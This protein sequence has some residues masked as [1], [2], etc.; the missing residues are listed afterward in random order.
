MPVRRCLAGLRS[1]RGHF[2]APRRWQSEGHDADK[3]GSRLSFAV[4]DTDSPEDVAQKERMVFEKYPQFEQL[5]RH[6]P[7]RPASA[8]RLEAQRHISE[9]AAKM[10]RLSPEESQRQLG[11]ADPADEEWFELDADAGGDD[12]REAMAEKQSSRRSVSGA[13]V[14]PTVPGVGV[15][16]DGMQTFIEQRRLAEQPRKG[17]QEVSEDDKP[18]VPP[19]EEELAQQ[20]T[21]LKIADRTGK[22]ISQ[23]VAEQVGPAGEMQIPQLHPH[24]YGINMPMV[25][26][27]DATVNDLRRVLDAVGAWADSVDFPL[28][29]SLN[30]YCLL[31][32]LQRRGITR[33]YHA[34]RLGIRFRIGYLNFGK[35]K[36]SCRHM[37]CEVNG[38]PVD[39]LPPELEA[40]VA[41]F[42]Q[43]EY[44]YRPTGPTFDGQ[45]GEVL[46]LQEELATVKNS[47]RTD[48]PSYLATFNPARM[49]NQMIQMT[50]FDT[51]RDFRPNLEPYLHGGNCFQPAYRWLEIF[52]KTASEVESRASV[53]SQHQA[54]RARMVADAERRRL[55]EPDKPVADHARD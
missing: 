21:F 4:K 3:R 32:Y 27:A 48:C 39:R 9:M 42:G 2:I 1:Y 40:A 49:R 26:L 12:S 53:L 6:K 25:K 43:P 54:S 15:S 46:D 28:F 41:E 35:G 14:E 17:R 36:L 38:A 8:E 22:T 31:H 47:F 16:S 13:P 44:A 5:V 11:F 37:W 50:G 24:Q 18:F 51:W 30:V 7:T 19:T 10:E 52:Y 55:S 33:P 23:V 20:E 45:T 29:S 34:A